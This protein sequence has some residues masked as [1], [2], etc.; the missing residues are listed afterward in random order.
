[1]RR[2]RSGL[3]AIV[4][5]P[6]ILV[7]AS[8]LESLATDT[9]LASAPSCEI[10]EL[11]LAESRISQAIESCDLP[12]AEALLEEQSNDSA[13]TAV[14]SIFP[15]NQLLLGLGAENCGQFSASLEWL[16]TAPPDTAYGDWRLYGLALSAIELGQYPAA[17]ASLDRLRTEY[18]N[19]P[20]FPKAVLAASNLAR[21]RGDLAGVAE[22]TL[23]SRQWQLKRETSRLLEVAAWQ[24]GLELDDDAL[25]RAVAIQLLVK[26]PLSASEL[27]VIEEFRAPDGSIEWLQFLTPEQIVQRAESLLDAGLRESAI[28][29]LESLPENDRGWR[30]HL[31]SARALTASGRGDEALAVLEGLLP[32]DRGQKSDLEWQRAF[33]ALEVSAPKPERELTAL[34]R[35]IMRARAHGHLEKAIGSGLDL[36]RTRRA[37]RV[38][39]EDALEDDHFE[40]A[41]KTLRRLKTIDPNDK[42][43]AQQLWHLGWKQ[44]SERNYSGAIGYW[45]EL[46]ALYPTSTYNRSGLYWT[47]RAHEV[48]GNTT[49]AQQLLTEVADVP[50]TDFYRRHAIRRLNDVPA[51]DDGPKE[52]TEPWPQDSILSRS[53]QL[54]S[55]GLYQ[56]ALLELDGLSKDA[57]SRAAAALKALT[58]A[59]AGNRRESIIAIKSVYPL[60][61]TPFQGVAPE[62]ARHLYYPLA[63]DDIIEQHSAQN[64][65]DR[66]L[67]LAMIRQE[68]AFDPEAKSWAGARGLMQVMPATGREIA[69]R[70]GLTYNRERLS[71]PSFSVQLGTAYYKQVRS[72]FGD[73]DE[74][75][76]A[77]YNAGPYRIKRL[78]RQAGANAELDRFLETLGLEETKSYVKRVLLFAD[79]YDRLYPDAG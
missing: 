25:R 55:F 19:S 62:R 36:E 20:L 39:F 18:S 47:A 54:A 12:R 42:S 28:D 31:V 16:R 75:S 35:Q 15:S 67:V 4:A 49:R 52:P 77:G 46:S 70:L 60:L 56:A 53:E 58:L 10:S 29:T 51:E 21:E 65:L 50:F 72:M 79:S 6:A 13:S 73:D 7:G 69:R 5:A 63:F 8:F 45:T 44:H 9:A 26:H 61:G 32:S 24:A 48:L 76:L 43:G 23:R 40:Q 57:D 27:E 3:L 11:S 14:D 17:N 30:W 74:L 38:L 64:E 66:N 41:L 37:L 68:S 2:F 71:D 22:I 34:Q 59:A 78:W 1:M 33:A